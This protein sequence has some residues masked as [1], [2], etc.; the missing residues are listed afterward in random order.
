LDKEKRRKKRTIERFKE[1][2][3]E[4]RFQKVKNNKKEKEN[5]VG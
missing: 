2:T 4:K 3:G 5:N 1:N